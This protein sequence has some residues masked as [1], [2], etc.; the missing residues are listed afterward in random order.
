MLFQSHLI[1]SV[2]GYDF[3]HASGLCLVIITLVF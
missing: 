2:E 3:V 1:E